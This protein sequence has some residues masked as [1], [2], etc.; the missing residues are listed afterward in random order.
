MKSREIALCSLSQFF[1]RPI[2]LFASA[3]SSALLLN[4]LVAHGLR[5]TIFIDNANF[6]SLG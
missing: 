1:A 5:P 6:L 2:P 4:D 3:Q